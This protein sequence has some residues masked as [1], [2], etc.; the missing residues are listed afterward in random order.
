MMLAWNPRH[1]IPVVQ[2]T[3]PVGEEGPGNYHRDKCKGPRL[4]GEINGRLKLDGSKLDRPFTRDAPTSR[5]VGMRKEE[6]ED[7]IIKLI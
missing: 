1:G 4:R 6:R 7:I 2:E 3:L 5:L